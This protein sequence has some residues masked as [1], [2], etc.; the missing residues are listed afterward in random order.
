VAKK[1]RTKS[2]T[3]PLKVIVVQLERA[4]TERD[5]D[6]AGLKLRKAVDKLGSEGVY[7]F[8]SPENHA[9]LGKV[10]AT[11]RGVG[12]SSAVA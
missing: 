11:T 2:L 8:I 5:L 4:L 7:E 1:S 12:T 10:A 6:L 9:L 3:G